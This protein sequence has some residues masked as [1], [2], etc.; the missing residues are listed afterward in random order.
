MYPRPF[1]SISFA[2]THDPS[3]KTREGLGSGDDAKAEGEEGD[4]A[5]AVGESRDDA[6]VVGEQRDGEKVEGG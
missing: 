3:I 5:E 6:T 4:G 1:C 2:P